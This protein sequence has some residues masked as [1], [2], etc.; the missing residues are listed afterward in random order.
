MEYIV[1]ILLLI[2][3][4]LSAQQTPWPGAPDLQSL[5]PFAAVLAV[6]AALLVRVSLFSRRLIPAPLLGLCILG[7]AS[8][9]L[10]PAPWV[11]IPAFGEK[12]AWI[13][14]SVLLIPLFTPRPARVL[15]YAALTL[16]TVEQ[17]VL[18][19]HQFSLLR[20]EVWGSLG[21]PN[22]LARFVLMTWPLFVAVG[23]FE[24]RRY[25]RVISFG[26]GLC[27]VGAG[28]L[29]LSRMA[30]L[31]IAVQA[32]YLAKR[33]GARKGVAIV[34]IT[35]VM[36]TLVMISGSAGSMVRDDDITRLKAWD[37]ALELSL[38]NP[39][40]GTGIGTFSLYYELLRSHEPG[41]PLVTPHSLILHL[42]C[43]LGL[44]AIPLLLWLGIWGWYSLS[45]IEM[46][47][48]NGIDSAYLLAAKATIIGMAVQSLV[49][50]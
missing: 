13:V 7:A 5:V 35:L 40:T 22:A 46:L 41:T 34:L 47:T 24:N 50:Y 43:E 9:V 6:I 45:G 1:R 29:T 2:T 25:L 39:L 33:M 42:A 8:A 31:A 49:E 21:T 20:T 18:V 15:L 36:I 12:L 38:R 14:A 32:V 27:L 17:L 44:L 37:T 10:S 3:L 23:S 48:T 30:F 16:L 19:V 11:A 28:L 4:L 26:L